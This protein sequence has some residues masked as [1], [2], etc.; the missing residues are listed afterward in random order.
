MLLSSP[1]AQAEA[2]S[3]VYVAPTI[4]YAAPAA[5]GA[6][7]PGPDCAWDASLIKYLVKYSEGRVIA[8]SAQPEAQ[9]K[10]L[11]MTSRLGPTV[12]EGE[13]AAPG[14]IEVTGT[15]LDEA[16]KPLGDFGFR[17]ERYSGSLHKC[18]RATQLA[19]GLADSIVNWLE[20]PSP[21][22]K[23]AE[24]MKVLRDDTIDAEINTTC[25]VTTGLPAYLAGLHS[26]TV[27]RVA[28]KLETA[29]G[30]RLLLTVVSSRFL[31]G[32]AYTGSK[33]MK[34][35]GSLLDNDRE[36]GSFIA[37]RQSFRGWTGC[38]VAD[39]V[40]NEIAYDI[41]NWL[42]KPSLNARLGD[43]DESTDALP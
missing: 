34:I 20:E 27:Y 29:Q 4:P 26:G 33:W 42:Q 15:L 9:G 17:D 39:R 43:A 30:K 28:D 10:K 40:S 11:V 32:G 24:S 2:P 3:P 41:Y 35:T 8:Q 19:E 5:N 22:I 25:P 37:L 31:G 36:I 7:A 6:T 12:G 13:K 18:K 14:W 23:I 1:V 21:A 38:S 16:G